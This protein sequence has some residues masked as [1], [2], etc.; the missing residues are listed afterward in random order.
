MPG[1]WAAL[2]LSALLVACSAHSSNR[3]GDVK[4]S[5]APMDARSA[6]ALFAAAESTYSDEKYDSARV[7]FGRVID[8]ATAAHDTLT[9]ARALTASGLAAWHLSDF[10]GARRFDE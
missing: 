8:R 9:L 10:R 3:T 7:Q 4:L 1:R 6:A 2:A 5:G